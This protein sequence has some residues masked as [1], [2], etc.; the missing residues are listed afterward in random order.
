MFISVD[1]IRSIDSC[2]DLQSTHCIVV[3]GLRE[4]LV[5]EYALDLICI[6]W[7]TALEI[8]WFHLDSKLVE[9][10]KDL[11]ERK[12]FVLLQGLVRRA[13]AYA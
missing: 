2:L 13:H 9:D 6:P 5:V 4:A 3:E 7:L 11:A 12:L 8:D 10:R 1:C